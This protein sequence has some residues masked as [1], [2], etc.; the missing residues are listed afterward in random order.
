MKDITQFLQENRDTIFRYLVYNK[1]N[2][3]TPEQI[4]KKYCDESVYLDTHYEFAKI[5]D[6]IETP[7]GLMLELDIY[8]PDDR[9]R[10]HRKD[11]KMID[12]ITLE[13]FDIDNVGEE[14][15]DC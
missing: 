8:D 11:Y 1:F 9:E 5:T 15:E 10:L 2:I 4:E 13:R 12:D 14:D 6:A 7:N 3:W